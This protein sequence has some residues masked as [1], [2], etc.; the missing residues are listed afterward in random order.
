MISLFRRS[1]KPND[2]IMKHSYNNGT[3]HFTLEKSALPIPVSE[4]PG[5][6]HKGA[7]DLL[8]HVRQIDPTSIKIDAVAIHEDA[9]M[10]WMGQQEQHIQKLL[11]LP[12]LYDGGL[13]IDSQG[14]FHQPDFQIN[15]YWQHLHGQRYTNAKEEGCFLH[16]AGEKRLLSVHAWKLKKALTKVKD[17]LSIASETTERMLQWHE[18]QQLLDILPDE[19]KQRIEKTSVLGSIRLFYASALRIDAIPEAGGYDIIPV[20][21][22]QRPKDSDTEDSTPEHEALL[23]PAEQE[24]Y[25]SFFTKA[26]SVSECT[27][28][29]VGRY[30]IINNDVRRILQHIQ[31]VR[32]QSHDKRLEFL[33][34]PRAALMQALEEEIDEETFA[35]ILSDRV[36][37]IGAWQTKVIPYVQMKGQE[38]VPDNNLPKGIIVRNP[39]TEVDTRI[40][41]VDEDEAKA[42]LKALQMAAKAGEPTITW[43]GQSVPA[44]SQ[45]IS[46][47]SGLFPTRPTDKPTGFGEGPQEP[48]E[49]DRN[50]VIVKENFEDVTYHVFRKPRLR[51]PK[52]GFPE[53]I[54]TEP[55]PH[56]KTG[57][58]W[59][60][61][62]YQ[63][64][65]RGVL[66]ADDMGLGKTWQAL[67]FL[68]WLRQGMMEGR[69]QQSPLLI[70]APTGLLR[71]WEKEIQDHL[72]DGLGNIVCAYG[73][74]LKT[75]RRGKK[76]AYYL[77]TGRLQEADLVLTTYETLNNYQI[78]FTAINFAAV[79]FD[80]MQ[81]VKNPASQITNAVNGIKA[82]F[83]LG[84]TGT[85]VENRL[86][87]LWCITDILQPGWL[88]SV[89]HFSQKFEKPLT[90][91]PPS[92][93][94]LEELKALITEPAKDGSPEY[95][96]R[97]MKK[98]TLVGLPLK[99]DHVFSEIMPP[100]QAT[101]YS[102]IIN[103][104]RN[105]DGPGVMLQALQ[106]MRAAS[107][108][109][110][111][112]RQKFYANDDAFI[113]DSARLKK[114]FSIL[115][116]IQRKRE[117]ALIFIEY[118]LWHQSDFLPALL[119]RK[120]NLPELPMIIN[121][122]VKG[123]DRQKRVERFQ[124]E[125]DV[126]DIM[127][128]SPKAGGVG[129]TLTAANHVI[130]LTRWWNP[131][132][133]DQAT[134]RV[135]RIGQKREVHVYYPMAIHPDF[136]NT[137]FDICLNQLLENKRRLSRDVLLP[138][139]DSEADQ[140]ELFKKTV[141]HKDDNSVTFAE[142]SQF[143]AKQF[144]SYVIQHLQRTASIYNWHVRSTPN[145]WDGGADVVVETNSGE[146][147]AVIQCKHS[148][149]PEAVTTGSDDIRRA[150][151]SY[152]LKRG[153]GVVITNAKA[154]HADKAWS[155]ENPE[156]NIILQQKQALFPE[157][158]ISKIMQ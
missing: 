117:K 145:S 41:V 42:L 155:N 34:N 88:G 87:D 85:P 84:M 64:G 68:A 12:P 11:N 123:Q 118:D 62:H 125:Q 102:N 49:Y 153:I 38:W 107:L 21:L 1:P 156:R 104:A 154:S 36:V 19:E 157:V 71:N 27:A 25:A 39:E 46:A 18:V 138:I 40:P 50:V 105:G 103:D 10:S 91:T 79:V 146:I 35:A 66:L 132:V 2:V 113:A 59:L 108:H 70:I 73:T 126:F 122:S 30:V 112:R 16:V 152:N 4:W 158:I 147:L 48:F 5:N 78:S 24:K 140:Q 94:A 58:D 63:A 14:T 32:K 22:R 3:I 93:V 8:D 106:R 144:E 44:T 80:E 33:K 95:M 26:N 92:Y 74:F 77:D 109:P 116:G 129:L 89:K 51:T 23:T 86:A 133:E 151:H 75:Y 101:E 47:V 149:N 124:A 17:R 97:R 143:T 53:Q 128:I 110:D 81:K 20:L 134:D 6:N 15:Y 130:H 76:D 28:L 7:N 43:Q 111:Y 150:I 55:K 82:D 136:H 29:D 72:K 99:R 121:G 56:Q 115:E 131:A 52:N 69:L 65:S 114:C 119:K 100:A 96:L 142:M 31:T 61:Q 120:F 57:F 45:T 135:Y 13:Q 83:W 9:L 37:G 67:A 139:L 137:S 148:S 54:R 141:W 127:L 98:N 90:D 60:C